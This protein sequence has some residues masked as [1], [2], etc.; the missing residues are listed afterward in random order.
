MTKNVPDRIWNVRS[1]PKR[2]IRPINRYDKP[3]STNATPPVDAPKIKSR[4]KLRLCVVVDTSYKSKGIRVVRDHTWHQKGQ[5]FTP[6]V[7]VTVHSI[8]SKGCC[9]GFNKIDTC[10]KTFDPP[11]I[12]T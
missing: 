11:D 8:V 7:Y 4:G 6:V 2:S 1:N 10:I 12:E 5:R 3:T 9:T